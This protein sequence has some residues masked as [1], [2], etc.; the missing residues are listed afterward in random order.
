MNPKHPFHL[1]LNQS[2]IRSVCAVL[3]VSAHR[4]LEEMMRFA[5][6][7]TVDHTTVYRLGADLCPRTGQAILSILWRPTNDSAKSGWN[8]YKSYVGICIG[9]DSEGNTW[10][11][12]WVPKEM[13]SSAERFSARIW[14]LYNQEPRVINVDKN[15]AYPPAIWLHLPRPNLGNYWTTA[16]QVP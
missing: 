8:L 16:R 7:H 1:C 9:H 12:D 13:R 6:A 4:H 3:A 15:A 2:D 5:W 11:H 10:Q 14:S